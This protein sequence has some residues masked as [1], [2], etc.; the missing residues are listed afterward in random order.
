MTYSPFFINKQGSGS[1]RAVTTNFQNGSGG[2][3]AM[4]SPVAINTSGQLIV[5]N[6][7]TEAHIQAMVGLTG[8]SI[9]NAATGAVVQSGRLEEVTTS[10][11]IG[12]SFYLSKT[13]GLTNVKPDI[14][15]GGFVAGDF[16]VFLGVVV[17]NEFNAILKDFKIMMS[18]IGQL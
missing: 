7:S 4:G 6:V 17:K 18:V 3:L 14:G 10:F 2:T 16:V 12:D 9:P 5:P 11:A 15:V 1:S 13:G 8:I